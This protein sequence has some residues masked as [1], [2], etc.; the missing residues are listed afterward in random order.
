MDEF[1]DRYPIS[2]AVHLPVIIRII[3]N[4]RAFCKAH[5]IGENRDISATF[6]VNRRRDDIRMLL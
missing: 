2:I 5:N 3:L 6:A 1:Y 4:D